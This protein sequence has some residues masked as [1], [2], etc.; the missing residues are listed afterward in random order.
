MRFALG[1][2]LVICLVALAVA[3][4]AKNK[5]APACSANCGEK[6]EPICAKAKN[7]NKERLLTFGNECV[8][9]NYNCQHSD[10][11]Y[12]MKSKGECGG[13]VSVRLS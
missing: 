7:G 3:T 2:F 5:Q 6:Y 1:L 4:P 11:P 10:D 12:E 13:N 9:G 8:M